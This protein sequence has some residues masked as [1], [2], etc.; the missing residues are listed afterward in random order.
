M[1]STHRA[2][3]HGAA[4]A[5]ALLA[6]V[7]AA[8]G[9][10][11][12]T[13]HSST[14]ADPSVT[15]LAGTRWGGDHWGDDK[16]QEGTRASAVDGVWHADKDNGSLF[17][18]TRSTG[19]QDAWK[20]RGQLDGTGVTV[21]LIDTGIASVAGLDAPGKVIQ[22]PD[23]SLESQDPAS[24]HLDGYGHGTHMAG[25]IAAR[26]T[27]TP[28]GKETDP[29]Y[30]VGMAPGARLLNVKVG[31]ADGGVDVTQV[32][33]AL[34]WVVAHRNDN[35]MN[36]RV[37]NLSYGTSSV[38]PTQ[39]DPLARAVENAW[40]HGVVVVVAAG[41]EGIGVRRLTMPAADPFVI[42]VGAS[43]HKGTSDV[44]DDTLTDF[45]NGGTLA[46]YADVLAPGQSLVGLRVP[47]SLIDREHPEGL[48]PGD[49]QGRFFR[50]SGTSQATAVVSGA[51]A[52]L[53]EQRPS[54]TPDQVKYLL[55]STGRNLAVNNWSYAASTLGRVLDVKAA[56]A[57]P[58]PSLTQAA[59]TFTRSTGL[60]SLEAARGASHVV[61]PANGQPL[62]GEQ[63][64][65][66]TAWDA[67]AWTVAQDADTVWSADM[68]NGRRWSGAAW[69][70]TA[71]SGVEWSGRRWSDATWSGGR[72]S[73]DDWS[74]R[75]WS[76]AMWSGRRWSDAGL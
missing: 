28:V 63:D 72:W 69:S 27:A 33:P 62:L 2:R 21:A 51:V 31:T 48:V 55:E 34:D 40:K 3:R 9:A 25:I 5:A 46:R 52:V 1:T 60:G 17:N 14:T 41:N 38:Q 37:I 24:A 18:V 35:G 75:R 67:N 70:G 39:V 68:W 13:H 8:A 26:D 49:T 4:A 12:A 74:G 32:I 76:D 30:T 7:A 42:A 10:G 65:F 58:T 61:D 43:D 23:L 50:G 29:R 6:L 11:A 47:G 22:G 57:A 71:W 44:R 54:L 15:T 19:A 53:L 59:Q 20:A 45:T 36:V 56:I 66:G 64:I 73:G 16:T